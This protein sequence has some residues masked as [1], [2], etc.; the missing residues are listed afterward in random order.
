MAKGL[1]KESPSP[2]PARQSRN[3]ESNETKRKQTIERRRSDA[4]SNAPANAGSPRRWKRV[5]S[6]TGGNRKH[7]DFREAYTML[8]SQEIFDR[9]GSE[10]GCGQGR[11]GNAANARC[12]GAAAIPQILDIFTVPQQTRRGQLDFRDI[13]F[14]I[15]AVAIIRTPGGGASFA[16]RA[17]RAESG[18]RRD[19]RIRRRKR[20][21]R[22][23]VA[24]ARSAAGALDR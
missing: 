10:H 6:S 12:E 11:D 3:C 13:D 17:P 18:R 8:R 20:G 2:Y 4:K 21:G 22:G 1:R 7:S 23:A 19:P 15:P 16:R 14:G 9:G 5:G 24:C